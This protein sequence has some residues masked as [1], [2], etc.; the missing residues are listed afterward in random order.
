MFSIPFTVLDLT[1]YVTA[2]TPL[3]AVARRYSPTLTHPFSPPSARPIESPFGIHFLFLASVAEIG[4]HDK[5]SPSLRR[6]RR[7][8]SPLCLS[9]TSSYFLLQQSLLLSAVDHGCLPIRFNLIPCSYS[10]SV[11]AL[12]RPFRPLHS[13]YHRRIGCIRIVRGLHQT[14]VAGAKELGAT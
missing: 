6:S 7:K 3:L 13:P 14:R 11:P 1:V 4:S 5:V 2:C 9:H 10:V 12:P 8:S